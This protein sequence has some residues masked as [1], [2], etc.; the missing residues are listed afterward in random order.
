MVADV[1]RSWLDD[2]LADAVGAAG[3]SDAPRVALSDP[4]GLAQKMTTD[5]RTALRALI[6]AAH[7]HPSFDPA[8]STIGITARDGRC[9][10]VLCARIPTPDH[11]DRSRLA[12]FVAVA[13]VIFADL[14][15][16]HDST[17]LTLRFSYEQR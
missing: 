14:Q 7:G 17:V 2:L 16:E 3:R 9:D 8:A 12:P 6:V 13:R 10:V 4:S 1:D 5:E 11:A 15:V